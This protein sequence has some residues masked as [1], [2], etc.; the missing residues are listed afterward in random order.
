MSDFD[1]YDD[2]PDDKNDFSLDISDSFA[3]SFF[4][5]K[6]TETTDTSN[7]KDDITTE[8]EPTKEEVSSKKSE[9]DEND[10]SD[11]TSSSPQTESPSNDIID[12]N[13]NS[14]AT[15]IYLAQMPWVRILF[16]FHYLLINY[17]KLLLLSVDHR[18]SN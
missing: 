18:C 8:H 14:N 2:S 3:D 17:N 6:K 10:R 9:K 13:H 4:S 11:I 1:L 5:T 16:Y 12:S 7:T 15:A